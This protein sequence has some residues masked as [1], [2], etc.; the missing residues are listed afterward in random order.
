MLATIQ[1]TD[2]YVLE[3]TDSEKKEVKA[4]VD[5]LNVDIHNM[6]YFTLNYLEKIS[7]KLP[8]RLIEELIFFKR[9]KNDYGTIL[10]RNLP[11]DSKLPNTPSDGKPSPEKHT[12]I[13]EKLLYLFMLNLGEPIAY[14]DEKNGQFVHDIC[15]IKGKEKNIENSGSQVFFSYHTEDAIHPYKPDYLALF[16]LRSDH[17]KSAKTETASVAKALELL[18]GYAIDIL[19]K[20]LF[21]LR[22]PS[23]FNSPELSIQTAILTG[24]IMRP[25][26]CI[27]TSLMEGINEEAQWALNELKNALHKVSIGIVL[28]PGDLVIIDNRLAAHA[29]TAFT[30]KY[31]GQDRWLQ[32]MFAIMDIRSSESSRSLSNN[33]CMPLKIELTSNN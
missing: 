9:V 4:L 16:C 31:D 32:R 15:P 7:K 5:S 21:I 12:N 11:I 1:Q 23:S 20:P 29:R 6:N 33:V 19:R 2:S 14:A 24:N 3:L 22:P 18:P 13:S 26:L 27:D 30:P 28:L 8:E 17:D 25:N 10:F